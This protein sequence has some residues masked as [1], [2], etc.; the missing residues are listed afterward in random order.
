LVPEL[1]TDIEAAFKELDTQGRRF[2]GLHAASGTWLGGSD[3]V[4]L[5]VL[6]IILRSMDLPETYAQAR[7]C[8][9]LRSNR[10]LDPVRRA[11]EA[12]GKEFR[13]ELNNLYVSPVLH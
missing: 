5:A 9:Y 1:P 7:F 12:A 3:S 6:G 4:R 11:V 13:R 2:G 8:L 10:F